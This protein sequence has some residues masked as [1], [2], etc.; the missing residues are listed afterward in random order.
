MCSSD[1]VGRGA[2]Q[3]YCI[4][5]HGKNQAEQNKRLEILS[6]TNDGFRIAEEDLK[7]RGPGDLFGIR[8]SGLLEFQIADIYRDASVMKDASEAAG[9]ILS[10]DPQLTLKQHIP[11]QNML[12][13]YVSRQLDDIGL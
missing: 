5:I 1:L 6:S 7:L 11:L 13:R 2:A 4:F 8:Q 12:E 10:L 9:E 3:S